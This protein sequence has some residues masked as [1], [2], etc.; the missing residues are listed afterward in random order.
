MIKNVN[1]LISV[2]T[3]VRNGR[4]FVEDTIVSA[5]AQ[6]YENY[7][8]IVIDGKSTD[9]TVG[10]IA[11]Y[12]KKIKYWISEKDAGIADAFNKGLSAANGDYIIFL[13]ADDYFVDSRVLQDTAHFIVKNNYPVLVYGDCEVLNRLNGQ[14]LYRTNIQLT[15]DGL[16]RGKMLPQPSL[17]T[18]RS[19]FEKYGIFDSKFKIAMDYEWLLRG[20]QTE[21][22]VHSSRIISR[23][24]NGGVSTRNQLNVINEIIFALRKNNYFKSVVGECGLRFYFLSRMWSRQFLSTLGLYEMLQKYRVRASGT[25]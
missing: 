23:V 14:V 16:R 3:V 19:Y 13:N 24:R 5:L 7:E 22:I 17:F 9:G 20:V 8:Y 1:P 21:K 15:V 10:I 2:V 25:K 6:N 18:H 12:A 11:S 4:E